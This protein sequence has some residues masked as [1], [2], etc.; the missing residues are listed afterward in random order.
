M[1]TPLIDTVPRLPAPALA[2]EGVPAV[3]IAAGAD[4]LQSTNVDTGDGTA[5]ASIDVS[6]RRRSARRTYEL[7]VLEANTF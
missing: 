7:N 1:G 6:V 3:P 5:T 2:A 4:K